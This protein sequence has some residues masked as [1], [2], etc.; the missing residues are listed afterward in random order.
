MIY[1][2]RQFGGLSVCLIVVNLLSD[3]GLHLKIF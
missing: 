3:N 1:T 2:L